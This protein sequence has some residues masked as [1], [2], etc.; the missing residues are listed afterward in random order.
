[1]RVEQARKFHARG[2][3]IEVAVLAPQR[4][5]AIRT[6]QSLAGKQRNRAGNI[7]H[8]GEIAVAM[9]HEIAAGRDRSCAALGN[10]SGQGSHRN[11]ITHQQTRKSDRPANHLPDHYRRCGGR[12]VGVDRAKHNMCSHAERQM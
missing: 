7:A 9:G 11:V 8:L 2:R 6:R 1:M 5:R 4:Q 10:R 3:D 12:R